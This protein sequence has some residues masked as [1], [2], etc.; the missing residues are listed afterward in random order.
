MLIVFNIQV[1]KPKAIAPLL[2]W[3]A[4]ILGSV[5]AEE[6]LEMGIKHVTDDGK[7]K[8]KSKT[9]KVADEVFDK[10]EEYDFDFVKDKPVKKKDGSLVI[11]P[12]AHDR[13]KLAKKLA[14]EFDDVIEMDMTR[15]G[16]A[17]KPRYQVNAIQGDPFYN[18]SL[19]INVVP[20]G[21][22]YDVMKTYDFFTKFHDIKLT[23]ISFKQETKVEVFSSVSGSLATTF[24][25]KGSSLDQ[26]I[27][28]T[29]HSDPPNITVF[30]PY[31]GNYSKVLK[32]DL[33]A[34][35]MYKQYLNMIEQAN[36][37]IFF[38]EGLAVPETIK[39]VYPA[40]KNMPKD[41]ELPNQKQLSNKPIII[42]NIFPP[43]DSDTSVTWE[44]VNN[45]YEEDNS[46]VNNVNNVYNSYIDQGDAITN[47]YNSTVINN[48]YTDVNYDEKVKEVEDKLPVVVPGDGDGGGST[49]VEPI[50]RGLLAYSKQM[51]EYLADSVDNTLAS[52][53]DLTDSAS[54]VVDFLDTSMD[55]LPSSWRVMFGSAFILGVVAH[56]LRR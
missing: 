55:W 47:V 22:S 24:D 6:A 51:Y 38:A 25:M 53:K 23:P 50:N 29:G 1:S 15:V 34:W 44:Q 19:A 45:R 32:V 9:A 42:P 14:D 54:G 56:F 8:K 17:T 5:I 41:F 4:S 39:N 52:L 37:K 40:P 11:T 16:K 46:I 28:I 2:V 31:S 7:S 3:G 12:S 30:Y 27:T 21:T 26:N 49:D 43:S 36:A 18:T 13:A 35:N 20:N 10:L 48:Y 33:V